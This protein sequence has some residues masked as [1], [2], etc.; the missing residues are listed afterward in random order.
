M[1]YLENKNFGDLLTNHVLSKLTGQHDNFKRRRFNKLP[2][3][4][5][6]IGVLFGKDMILNLKK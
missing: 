1:D 4:D 3:G 5:I 2:S 6:P